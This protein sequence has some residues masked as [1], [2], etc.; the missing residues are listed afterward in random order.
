MQSSSQVMC[1]YVCVCVR[2]PW[3]S[4]SSLLCVERLCW[5]SSCY[6]RG[7]AWDIWRGRAAWGRLCHPDITPV[8]F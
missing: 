7:C 3:C 4:L 8:V 1:V 5:A 6:S 2:W